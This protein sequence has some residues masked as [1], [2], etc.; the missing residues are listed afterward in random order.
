[1][2]RAKETISTDKELEGVLNEVYNLERYYEQSK[3]WSAYVDSKKFKK[4]LYQISQDILKHEERL[5][6]L[7]SGLDMN[8]GDEI[9]EGGPGDAISVLEELLEG[10]RTIKNIYEG[11]LDVDKSLIEKRWRGKDPEE[12]YKELEKQ[13][14]EEEGHIREIM[15]ML[16]D[17]EVLEKDLDIKEKETDEALKEIK[18]SEERLKESTIFG[19]VETIIL[20]FDNL[21]NFNK[22]SQEISQKGNVT[23]SSS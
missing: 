12:F 22:V 16:E 23:S 19:Q 20:S 3:V 9:P 11:L 6:R 15:E 18:D 10:E 5:E 2:S 1:M 21:K 7:A 4:V 14:N 13:I 8:L 17:R